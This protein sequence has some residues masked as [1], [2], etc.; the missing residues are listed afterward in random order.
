MSKRKGTIVISK[1]VEKMVDDMT[2]F[3]DDLMSRVFD[4]NIPAT[5]L[6]IGTILGQKVDV[7]DS[8]GQWDMKNP[9]VKGRC[10]TLDVFAKDS[11]GRHFN[12]E[13]QRSN[14]GA[15]PQRARFHSAM[16][17]ARMLKESQ[18]F[19]EIKDSYAIFITKNDYYNEGK[20][21]YMVERK[22]DNGKAFGDGNH[23]IYVNGA[24]AGNDDIGRLM[25]DFRSKET[26]GFNNQVL[27]E[28]VRHFKIDKEG[29][30]IMCEA[31]EKYAEE[32]AKERYDSGLTQGK[33][34]SIR[35]LIT[36]LNLTAEQAMESIGI[37]RSEYN[38]YLKL[39]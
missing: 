31:V 29:R 38:K 22:R 16:V 35:A 5:Q 15:V 24:Y 18:E 36:N 37:P 33:L 3:D 25:E 1:K 26:S 9:I 2:L 17:D 34:E 28:G 10:I 21:V 23:I 39:I 7:I 4:N 6:L 14:A 27:E 20:P 32:C 30:K 13:V 8:K 11:K 19:R 12:C